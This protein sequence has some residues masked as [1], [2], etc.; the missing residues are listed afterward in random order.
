YVNVDP[1]GFRWSGDQGPWPPDPK[2]FNIFFF[3][4]STGFGYGVRDAE[5][6]ASQLAA[7][8]NQTKAVSR[9]IK[10][11][12]FGRAGYYS[13]PERM[14]FERLLLEGHRPQLAVF[15][16][17]LNEFEHASDE[18]PRLNHLVDRWVFRPASSLGYDLAR[19]L[20]TQPLKRLANS[21][22]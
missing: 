1:G 18:D 17:G 11:Y 5:T 21:F 6:V 14:L 22:S 13:T 12:N 16:D 7:F 10:I 20:I 19:T 4:G 9:P 3:G 15:M 2:N 8:L